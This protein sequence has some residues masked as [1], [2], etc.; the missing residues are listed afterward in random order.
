MSIIW[1]EKT[2]EY[3]FVKKYVDVNMYIA[4]LDGKMEL[5]GDT[6]FGNVSGWILIEFKRN[7]DTIKDEIQKYKS[8]HSAKTSLAERDNH[9]LIIYGEAINNQVALKCQR[10]FSEF[11]VSIDDAF[12]VG[13]PLEDFKQYLE[14]LI[15]YKSSGDSGTGDFSYVA[16]ID[17]RDRVIRCLTL[18]E[19]SEG[20]ELE[21]THKL[22]L[23]AYLQ[24]RE[25]P[26]NKGMRL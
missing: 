15:E 20:F 6:I 21:K 12:K 18:K 26:K 19:F 22:R 3:L 5:G 8:Y 9:H 11:P 17:T 7:R 24:S 14:E 10:Y 1:W 16:G 4:P 13:I 25:P 23:K 2:V